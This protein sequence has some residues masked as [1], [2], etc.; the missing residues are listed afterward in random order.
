MLNEYLVV[1]EWTV[2]QPESTQGGFSIQVCVI[3]EQFFPLSSTVTEQK[4]AESHCQD[5][6]GDSKWLRRSKER[7][8]HHLV[9][10]KEDVMKEWGFG[11]ALKVRYWVAGGESSACPGWLERQSDVSK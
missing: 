9:V 10:V 5:Q 3:Q 4:A 2:I 8:C 7:I 6:C 11:R 1:N